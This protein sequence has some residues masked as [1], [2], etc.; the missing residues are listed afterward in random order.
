MCE[1]CLRL[2]KALAKT[3][4]MWREERLKKAV[5]R[6]FLLAIFRKIHPRAS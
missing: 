4:R 3:E 6:P 2:E 1:N 5:I